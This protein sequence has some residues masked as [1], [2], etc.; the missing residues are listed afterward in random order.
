[1]SG[2]FKVTLRQN[3]QV[4]F[5]LQDKA[6]GCSIRNLIHGQEQVVRFKTKY[7]VLE[8][9]RCSSLFDEYF[10]KYSDGSC[11]VQSLFTEAKNN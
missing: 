11:Y 9:V 3:S 7:G 4:I 10:S 1:M 2:D 8:S 5:I 6:E